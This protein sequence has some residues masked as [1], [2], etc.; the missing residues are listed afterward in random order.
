MSRFDASLPLLRRRSRGTAAAWILSVCGLLLAACAASQA[1]TETLC[2]PGKQLFCR[3]QDRGA[4]TKTCSS[5]G[6]SFSPCEPCES[7]DNPEGPL[8]P[9]DPRGPYVPKPPMT[10]DGGTDGGDGGDGGTTSMSVCG[11]GEVQL[12]EDCDDKNAVESDGCS[13]TCT[14][15]GTSTLASSACP[16]LEV[17]VWGGAH[18]PTL[19]TT[20]SG[21]GNRTVTPACGGSDGGVSPSSGST[22]PDRVFRVVAHKTG[23]LD[24]VTSNSDFAMLLY[25]SATCEPGANTALGCANEHPSAGAEALSLKVEAG[26]TYH[27]FVDGHGTGIREG[28]FR[29]SFQIR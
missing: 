21:S 14:L 15:S 16:G 1:K 12:N 18:K 17:H 22:A 5:D 29:I 23:T 6:A 24:V 7:D 4:G 19:D 27:V 20:T 26:K 9:G 13:S 11:D 28:A 8:L 25:A 2:S 10:P 3:C